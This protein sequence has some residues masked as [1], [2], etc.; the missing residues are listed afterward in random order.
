[1]TRRHVP[2]QRAGGWN[3]TAA[4]RARLADEAA[5]L[6]VRPPRLP[7]P[8]PPTWLVWRWRTVADPDAPPAALLPAGVKAR[9]IAHPLADRFGHRC[10]LLVQSPSN[11]NRNRLVIFDDGLRVVAPQY[12]TRALTGDDRAGETPAQLDLLPR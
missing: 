1:M 7:D 12:A 11:S 5:T 10:R 8:R 9:R 3:V 6:A 2:D 4:V